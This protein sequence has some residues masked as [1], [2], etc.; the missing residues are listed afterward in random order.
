MEDKIKLTCEDRTLNALGWEIE[1]KSY[2]PKTIFGK[3]KKDIIKLLADLKNCIEENIEE[4]S[5]ILME[6][7]TL[8]Q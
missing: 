4:T 6:D 1:G 5:K 7:G 8:K 3:D 2:G